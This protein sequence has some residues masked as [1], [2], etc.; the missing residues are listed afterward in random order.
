MDSITAKFKQSYSNL[1]T[2]IN[3]WTGKIQ[4]R[5]LI[6]EQRKASF[7]VWIR[8]TISIGTLHQICDPHYIPDIYIIGRSCLEYSASLRGVMADAGLAKAYLEFPDRARA[9]YGKVLE[10][11]GLSSELAKLEPVLQKALGDDWRKKKRM[12]WLQG[13]KD[14][15][16]S[17]LVEQYGGTNER[18]LYAWWSH[19]T[20]GSAVSVEILQRTTPTQD[21]L[22]K[23][24]ETVYGAYG[25]STSDFLDFA[26]GSVITDDSQNCKDEFTYNVM[27][28]YI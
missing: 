8:Y 14:L 7:Y 28:A 16:I 13:Q 11:L 9:Y 10:N 22:D 27:A 6:D 5:C 18:L 4:D 20:H 12:N 23:I 15:N 21:Q 25:L 3:K 17:K 26:W 19:F 24:V 2:F 1:I